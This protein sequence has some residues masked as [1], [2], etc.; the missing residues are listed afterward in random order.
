[1][2]FKEFCQARFTAQPFDFK[3]NPQGFPHT[4]ERKMG[5]PS[6]IVAHL[7]FISYVASK[8]EH[9]TEFGVRDGFSTAALLNSGCK[10]LV[11]YDIERTNAIIQLESFISEIPCEWHF[12]Q[13]STLEENL[14]FEDTDFLLI[15]SLH[16][17]VQVEQELRFHEQVR[18]YIGLHDTLSQ[19]ESSLDVP[20]KQGILYAIKPFL[21]LHEE[22]HVVY[23]VN[24]NHGF[25][26]L[27]KKT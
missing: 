1:M 6:D 20:G 9:C 17:S 4:S 22:W 19:G 3:W 8:C 14:Q 10:R 24:F 25:T 27:E 15:D 13:K 16:T 12:I 23:H 5:N 21:L 26:L 7:P 11:S 2:N 18:R